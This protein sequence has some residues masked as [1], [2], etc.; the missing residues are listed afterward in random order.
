[1]VDNF[2]KLI[3]IAKKLRKYT[4]KL[5]NQDVQSQP[6]FI[7]GFATD[8]QSLIVDLNLCIADLKLQLAERQ[9]EAANHQTAGQAGEQHEAPTTSGHP[10]APTS[11]YG[12]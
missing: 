2:D 8:V 4:K 5:D 3:D 9:E 10:L 7:S 12:A 6:S 1:M 11:T